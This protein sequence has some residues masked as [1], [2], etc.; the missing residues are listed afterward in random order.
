MAAGLA[1]EVRITVR[2]AAASQLDLTPFSRFAQVRAGVTVDDPQSG[3]LPALWAFISFGVHIFLW[4][5]E[6]YSPIIPDQAIRLVKR[7]ITTVNV[8]PMNSIPSSGLR[9]YNGGRGGP[10]ANRSVAELPEY[11]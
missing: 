1:M 4:N 9:V 6:F 8:E 3:H 10:S 5:W 11:P 7:G 2:H